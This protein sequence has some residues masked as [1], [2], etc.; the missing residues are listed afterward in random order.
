ME[1]VSPQRSIPFCGAFRSWRRTTDE[2]R[3][4]VRSTSQLE[5]GCLPSLE[6]ESPRQHTATR[7][8][9][10]GTVKF[11]ASTE[12]AFVLDASRLTA[13]WD[14]IESIADEVTAEMECADDSE[15]EVNSLDAVLR[16]PNASET[17]LRALSI[18]GRSGD[19]EVDVTV[20]FESKRTAVRSVHLRVDGPDETAQLIHNRLKAEIAN[21]KPWYS[22]LARG[23]GEVLVA[24]LMVWLTMGWLLNTG[25][26]TLPPR[27]RFYLVGL[28]VGAGFV[29]AFRP[30]LFPL[31]AF[32]LGGRERRYEVGDKVR[33]SLTIALATGT[34]ALIYRLLVSLTSPSDS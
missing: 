30:R 14:Y 2:T 22:F 1:P 18:R 6:R 7:A 19:P 20:K 12:H 8:D 5:S 34:L 27:T 32:A 13:I 25:V 33:R 28:L 17:Q 16:H 11:S 24:I 3:P 9:R 29:N 10:P 15:R 4:R 31:G 23:I 26:V 21:C